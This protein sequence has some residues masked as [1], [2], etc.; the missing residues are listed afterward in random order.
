MKKILNLQILLVMI[1]VAI[2]AIFLGGTVQ[3]TESDATSN[4]VSHK[5]EEDIVDRDLLKFYFDEDVSEE[6]ALYQYYLNEDDKAVIYAANAL[7]YKIDGK[8]SYV[9]QGSVSVPASIDGHEVAE[10]APTAFSECNGITEIVLVGGT[11]KIGDE[12]FRNCE[13]LESVIFYADITEA[14]LGIF[15]DCTSLKHVAWPEEIP[16]IPARTFQGCTAL[17]SPIISE[18]ITALGP[19]CFFGCTSLKNLDLPETLT[20]IGTSAFYNCDS[21]EHISI[22]ENVHEIQGS[23]F[24]DCASLKEIIFKKSIE[25]IAEN[26]FFN[27]NP[28]LRILGFNG[29]A[30][31][32]VAAQNNIVFQSMD[33]LYLE[34]AVQTTLKDEENNIEVSAKLDPNATLVITPIEKTSE[35]YGDMVVDLENHVILQVCDISVT[36]GYVGEIQVTFDVDSSYNGKVLTVL[37]KKADTTIEKLQNTVVDG[38]LTVT[39]TELSPFVVAISNQ[40]EPTTEQGDTEQTTQK[41]DNNQSD[42]K[43]ETPKTGVANI[44][45]VAVLGTMLSALGLVVVAKKKN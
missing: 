23:T 40:D 45:I 22:S 32:I 3:A 6:Y 17:E 21:L 36:G 44:T 34:D 1:L 37:H 9:I 39:V 42:L 28:E 18:G 26:A 25:K 14:G 35:L 33:V 16:E 30:A 43:D 31:Q 8:P 5:N 2:I 27:P 29:T 7:A 24:A 4:F 41:E 15:Q 10:I 12:A 20:S 38:K 13:A 11:M 19:N